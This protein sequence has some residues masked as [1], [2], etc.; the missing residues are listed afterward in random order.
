MGLLLCIPAVFAGLVWLG[1]NEKADEFLFG[2]P[3]ISDKFLDSLERK[4]PD[5]VHIRGRVFSFER[6]PSSNFKYVLGIGNKP[7]RSMVVFKVSDSFYRIYA[8]DVENGKVERGQQLRLEA[9]S[10]KQLN[11]IID[12]IVFSD[13]S[14]RAI[15]KLAIIEE[16]NRF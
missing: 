3:L 13:K 14:K 4:G 16:M 2:P 5:G 9:T 15:D 8:D 12:A 7:N 11:A 10:R 6:K 1:L